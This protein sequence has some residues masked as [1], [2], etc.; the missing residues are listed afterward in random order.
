MS[1]VVL[2]TEATRYSGD[3]GADNWL[4]KYQEYENGKANGL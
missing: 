2:K 4:K 1:N 3:T